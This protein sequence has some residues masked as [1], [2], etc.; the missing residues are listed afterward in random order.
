M[1][2]SETTETVDVAP[3]APKKKLKYVPAIPSKAAHVVISVSYVP[4][5][6]S[7]ASNSSADYRICCACPE[8]KKIRDQCLVKFNEDKCAEYIE[9]HKI[10]L[11]KEGFNV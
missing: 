1:D 8:T 5:V 7:M 2:P 11:R 9:A 4:Y 6:F 10:C 3:P